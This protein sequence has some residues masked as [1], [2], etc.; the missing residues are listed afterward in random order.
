MALIPVTITL[1]RYAEPD[2]LVDEALDSLGQQ[3]GV[4]GEVIFLDQNWR[5]AYAKTVEARSNDRLSFKCVPCEARCLSFARNEGLRLAQYRNVLF[6]EPDILT[7][8]DWALLLAKELENG[9]AIAGSR[10]LPKWR[11]RMPLMSKSRIVQDQFSLFDLGEETREIA[12]PVRAIF[13]L[14]PGAAGTPMRFD[15]GLGR[16]NGRLLGGEETDLCERVRASGGRIVYCGQSLAV[17]QILPERLSLS[18]IFRRLYFAGVSR[19]SRGGAPA[20]SRRPGF[21]DWVLLPVI[22]PPYAIG[23]ARASAKGDTHAT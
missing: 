4:T 12:G 7:A 3:E 20:P 13:G 11:G 15:E 14:R 5:E 9:A 10:I 17:H 21:W 1:T 8:P 19:R 6:S 18:W 23:Y 22:L 16:R 2:W